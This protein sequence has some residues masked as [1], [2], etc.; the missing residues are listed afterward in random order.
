MAMAFRLGRLLSV[1]AMLANAE[2][3]DASCVDGLK[4]ASCPFTEGTAGDELALL[5]FGRTV[6]HVTHQSAEFITTSRFGLGG[7][8]KL[9]GELTPG[10]KVAKLKMLKLRVRRMKN[11]KSKK[12]STAAGKSKTPKNL[13]TAEPKAG[14]GGKWKLQSKAHAGFNFSA[15]V[16]QRAKQSDECM[17]ADNGAADRDG[18]VC[19]QYSVYPQWCGGYDDDD[20]LSAAMCCACGGGQAAAAQADVPLP[21]QQQQQQSEQP[22][23]QQQPYVVQETIWWPQSQAAPPQPPVA[24]PEPPA[25]QV[26]PEVPVAPPQLPAAPTVPEM[27]AAPPQPLAAPSSPEEPPAAPPQPPAAQSSPEEPPAAPPQPPATPPQ[28]GCVDADNGAGDSDGDTCWGYSTHPQ[29]CGAYDD[30]DFQ[31]LTMCCVCGGGSEPGSQEPPSPPMPES[32]QVC[33]DTDAGAADVDGDVCWQYSAFPQWCSGYDDDDFT[34]AVMCCACGG[35]V[36][37]EQ[38]PGAP[39]DEQSPPITPI[40]G[41][42]GVCTD[43]DG[44]AS[45]RD[46]DYCWAYTDHPQW[47]GGYDDEDFTSTSMCCACGGGSGSADLE[48]SAG[49]VEKTSC[50]NTDAGSDGDVDGDHCTDYS[51]NPQWCTDG[52]FGDD[53]FDA[54]SMC[55][56]CGGGSSDPNTPEGP[57]ASAAQTACVD[58]DAGS[59]GDQDGDHC[60]DYALNRHWCLGDFGDDDF[61]AYTMCCVCGGG[62]ALSNSNSE[63][64]ASP[65]AHAQST[66]TDSDADSTGDQDGDGCV[67][68]AANPDWCKGD[69]GDDDFNAPSMCCVCGGG[70]AWANHIF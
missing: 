45:D 50:A 27:P 19:W 59:T 41:A 20:F 61:D 42:V 31:S 12:A 29:W 22:S 65:F 36:S 49:L 54:F 32:R 2:K 63:A 8:W 28:S 67:E 46:G 62:T 24:A 64:A 13:L 53:D 52:D 47:C 55:C 48:A 11:K 33:D 60:T 70:S 38:P 5:H 34:S 68:Y 21:Q 57:A 69:F 39:V 18:D 15:F 66:C 23:S 56:A 26:V 6:R 35:G 3:V 40:A 30:E 37:G 51:Y 14:V 10:G 4:T 1:S 58:G 9:G 7:K 43:T 17:D 44:A 16:F 25:I